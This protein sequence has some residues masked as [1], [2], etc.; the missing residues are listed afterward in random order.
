MQH[1]AV[2]YS[3]DVSHSGQAARVL[4]VWQRAAAA[5]LLCYYIAV[6]VVQSCLCAVS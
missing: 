1:S 2:A 3:V 5:L 4:R 6:A